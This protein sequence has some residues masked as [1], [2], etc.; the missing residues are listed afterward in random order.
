MTLI[1]GCR[2]TLITAEFSLASSVLSG[3][4]FILIYHLFYSLC[5]VCWL[6]NISYCHIWRWIPEFWLDLLISSSFSVCCCTFLDDVPR[7]E[8]VLNPQKTL[9][10]EVLCGL[11]Y[12]EARNGARPLSFIPKW[13]RKGL[14]PRGDRGFAWNDRMQVEES[15]I[16]LVMCWRNATA[17]QEERHACCA[18]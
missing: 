8:I 1:C 6:H 13:G 7:D 16:L 15:V 17:S 12:Q 3:L 11:C 4:P 9:K 14:C 5:F 18:H 10:G 2:H